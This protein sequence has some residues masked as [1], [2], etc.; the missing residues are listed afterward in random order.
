MSIWPVVLTGG[1]DYRYKPVGS[2]VLAIAD[3]SSIMVCSALRFRC[4]SRK[5]GHCVVSWVVA[6]A[7]RQIR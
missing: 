4:F 6:L 1:V 5:H 2:R 7:G 3:S